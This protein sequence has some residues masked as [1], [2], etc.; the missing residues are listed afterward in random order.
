MGFYALWFAI[1][2]VMAA[3]L[4]EPAFTVLAKHFDDAPPSDGAR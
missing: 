4:Y 2:L 3:A 1:G